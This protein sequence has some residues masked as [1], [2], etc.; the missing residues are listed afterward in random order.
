MQ[1]C[2]HTICANQKGPVEGVQ[3]LA[4]HLDIKCYLNKVFLP[5][6]I[7]RKADGQIKQL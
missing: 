3:K 4:V 2:R 6:R 7:D 1:G 5:D